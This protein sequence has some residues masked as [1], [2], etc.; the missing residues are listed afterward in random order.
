MEAQSLAARV[1]DTIEL[2]QIRLKVL[3]SDGHVSDMAR[4]V[5]TIH[6]ESA[7]MWIEHGYGIKNLPTS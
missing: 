2:A 4:Q 3:P 1:L 6:L 7:V 5:A